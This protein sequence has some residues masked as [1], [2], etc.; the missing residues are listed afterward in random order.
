MMMG[1]VPTMPAFGIL[2]RDEQTTC[3]RVAKDDG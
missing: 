3:N 1:K 2:D